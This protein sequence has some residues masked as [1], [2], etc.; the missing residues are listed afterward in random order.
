MAVGLCL[1]VAGV[2]TGCAGPE[3]Q[4][5][6]PAASAAASLPTSPLEGQVVKVDSEGLTKVRGFV[7][8]TD[9]GTEIA[10]AVGPLENAVEFPPSHLSEHMATGAPVR[11]SFRQE[12]SSLVVYRIEDASGS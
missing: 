6:L 10:F 3:G 11:I 7:L 2:V 5:N 4:A 8:R 9:S 1:V 12:G